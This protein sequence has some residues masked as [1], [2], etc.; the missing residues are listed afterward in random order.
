MTSKLLSF[1]EFDPYYFSYDFLCKHVVFWFHQNYFR[2]A[3]S[4]DLNP[5]WIFA[6][7]KLVKKLEILPSRQSEAFTFPSSESWSFCL[8]EKKRLDP[9]N[10]IGHMRNAEMA[11]RD[12]IFS[13]SPISK[14]QNFVIFMIS[15]E[16]LSI[17]INLIVKIHKLVKISL[18]PFY[19]SNFPVLFALSGFLD[20]RY[21]TAVSLKWFIFTIRRLDSETWPNLN[22]MTH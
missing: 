10:R 22:K 9:E 19:F 20:L 2:L 4:H 1:H 15:T 14:I 6:Q 16:I 18:L 8:S 7:K 17:K 12:E 5:E 11:K 13:A 3:Q 21:Q